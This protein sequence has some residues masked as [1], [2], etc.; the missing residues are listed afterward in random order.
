M[1]SNSDRRYVLLRKP[2]AMEHHQSGLINRP[3]LET[4]RRQPDQ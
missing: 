4:A 2:I 1:L 3:N